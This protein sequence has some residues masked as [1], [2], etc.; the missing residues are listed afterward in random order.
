MAEKNSEIK[1][2]KAESVV[3]FRIFESKSKLSYDII[4][5]INQH[6]QHRLYRTTTTRKK[7]RAKK[8]EAFAAEWVKWIEIRDGFCFVL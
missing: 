2:N 5:F 7:K 6:H 3:G 1:H 4:I 8:N